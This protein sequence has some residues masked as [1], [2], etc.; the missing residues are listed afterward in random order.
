MSAIIEA[1]ESCALGFCCT[2]IG[3]Y[4]TRSTHAFMFTLYL[5]MGLFHGSTGEF[6]KDAAIRDSVEGP[7]L[8]G[9]RP[10]R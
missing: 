6:D 1:A 5:T 8:V 9:S 2:S 4:G 3:Y 10:S 7:R